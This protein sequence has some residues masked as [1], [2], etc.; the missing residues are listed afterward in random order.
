MPYI[1]RHLPIFEQL[2]S[3]WTWI[4][5]E[6]TS[7]NVRDTAWCRPQSPGLS[8]DGTSEYLNS[9]IHHPRVKVFRR[10][11]WN[12][13]VAMCNRAIAGLTEPCVL[14]QVDVDEFYTADQIDKIVSIFEQRPDVYR[15]L[16]WCRYFLGPD[17]VATSTD[18][19]GNRAGVEWLRAFRFEPDM[20]FQK[21][22]PPV[23]HNNS[24]GAT[25]ERDE[26]RAMGLVFD[27]FAWALESQVLAK[28]R[29]Y[30]YRNAVAQW[31]KLQANT[32]WPIDDL[33][34]FL[35]WVGP[36]ASADKVKI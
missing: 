18:G 35:N 1:E 9:V 2:K 12:G 30:G 36:N 15:M 27:H 23:L 17:I 29:F 21:H 4:V 22:E 6:G 5:V 24:R 16:F 20:V 33:R 28:E 34:S 25:M 11:L 26:T 19:Y 13:K 32:K 31:R 3:D 14:L 8:R 7:A 10:Q